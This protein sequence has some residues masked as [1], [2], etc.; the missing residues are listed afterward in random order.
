MVAIIDR[1]RKMIICKFMEE[2]CDK[3]QSAMENNLPTDFKFKD[4]YSIDLFS[5]YLLNIGLRASP[6]EI[7][8]LVLDALRKYA[9]EEGFVKIDE[10]IVTLT[11]KGLLKCQGSSRSW[12]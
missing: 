6:S 3:H 12:D 4:F 8:K 7:R 2:L 10:N 11:E 5:K 9:E 1:D